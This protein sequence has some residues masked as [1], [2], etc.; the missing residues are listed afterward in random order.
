MKILRILLLILILSPLSLLAGQIDSSLVLENSSARVFPQERFRA[1][2]KTKI[3]IKDKSFS[4]LLLVREN[5]DSSF[6]IAFVTEVGMKIFEFE[7]FPR[8]KD[9]FHVVSILSYLD[10]G[11]ILKT[12]RRDFES[13][14]MGFTA[15][16]KPKIK[17]LGKASFT[18]RYCYEGKRIYFVQG[19]QILSMT[20]SKFLSTKEEIHFTY[21]DNAFPQLI[22][23][24]HLGVKLDIEMKLIKVNGSE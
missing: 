16:K 15:F 23:I 7:F 8:K 14:F 10:R 2:Y 9:A 1:V 20:R 3:D 13:L 18:Q 5:A 21:G 12:L 6:R 19:K 11:I 24:H 17:S 22:N 4:G